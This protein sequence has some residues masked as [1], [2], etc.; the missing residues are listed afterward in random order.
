L[1]TKK[2]A[3]KKHAQQRAKERYGVELNR[4]IINGL[5][6]QIREGESTFIEKISN[7]VTKHLVVLDGKEIPVIYDKLRNTIVTFLSQ[8]EG[9]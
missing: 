4:K 8:A 1:T 7:R 6:L 3:Q 9:E 5:L 2:D